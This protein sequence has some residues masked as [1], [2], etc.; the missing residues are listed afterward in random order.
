MPI[1]T[2][3]RT[4]QH[5]KVKI[6]RDRFFYSPNLLDLSQQEV[7]TVKID[8]PETWWTRLWAKFETEKLQKKNLSVDFLAGSKSWQISKAVSKKIVNQVNA[9]EL[10]KFLNKLLYSKNSKIHRSLA[11]LGLKFE[12]HPWLNKFKKVL[13]FLL[14][15]LVLLLPIQGIALSQ[16][17]KTKQAEIMSAG[18]AGYDNFKQAQANIEAGDFSGAQQNFKSAKEKFISAEKEIGWWRIFI[19]ITRFVVKESSAYYLLESAKVVAQTGEELT[20]WVV[21]LKNEMSINQL[22][23]KELDFK[24]VLLQVQELADKREDLEIRLDKIENYLAKVDPSILDPEQIKKI[25]PVKQEALRFLNILEILPDFLGQDDMRRYLVIFQNS[26]EIR[27]TGGFMGSL[28]LIDVNQGKITKIEIPGGGPYDLRAG[29][30]EYIQA[31]QPLWRIK[32]RWEIQDA[33]WWP[34]FPTSAKK[35]AWFYE[36]SDQPTVDGVIA[37]NSDILPK[38]LKVFGPITLDDYSKTITADNFYELTQQQVEVD[39]DK[40]ENQPKQFIA[41]LF[42]KMIDNLTGNFSLKN[43]QELEFVS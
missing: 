42:F 37:V 10:P 22:D 31:P 9:W 17:F 32:T 3:K 28:A 16:K 5:K 26:N 13:V 40:E 11:N 41:D 27:A 35:I 20:G 25:E 33:N 24:A 12:K 18:M 1:E 43:N 39:Y 8:R 36:N 34:D 14:V 15:C 7:S 21:D 38:L 19:P 29:L 2:Q 4:Y 30:K 23:A 6:N